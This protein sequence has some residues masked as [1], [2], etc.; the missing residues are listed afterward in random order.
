MPPK[1]PAIPREALEPLLRVTPLIAQDSRAAMRSDQ[2]NTWQ[3]RNA[4]VAFLAGFAERECGIQLPN[5][6]LVEAFGLTASHISTIRAQARKKEKPPHHP[7]SLT[8][9]EEKVIRE[10]ARERAIARI[11]VTQREVLNFVETEFRKTLT[12][13]WLECFL[14]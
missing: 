2:W 9:D 5:L 11:Y 4:Q 8:D 13:G 14:K 6:S 7:L 12:H 1:T 3:S 10:M